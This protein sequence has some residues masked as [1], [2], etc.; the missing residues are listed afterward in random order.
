M[1]SDRTLPPEKNPFHSLND[2]LREL[3]P[4]SFTP[5]TYTV[6]ASNHSGNTKLVDALNQMDSQHTSERQDRRIPLMEPQDVFPTMRMS[7]SVMADMEY[8][9]QDVA[10]LRST[11]KL[12]AKD[13]DDC[14]HQRLEDK[15]KIE[16]DLL[17]AVTI[18]GSGKVDSVKYL[19]NSLTDKTLRSCVQSVVKSTAF[20]NTGFKSVT[21]NYQFSFFPP[22]DQRFDF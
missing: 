13:V 20:P 18:L 14:Y 2:D 11:L 19:E 17:L 9:A 12:R 22:K 1:K 4:K 10:V 5:Q 7:A 6:H 21:I 8:Y 3:M 16:G 15:A